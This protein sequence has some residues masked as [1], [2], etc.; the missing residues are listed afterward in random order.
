MI[1][2][3]IY[4]LIFV[5]AF[6]VVR[7]LASRLSARHDF[8]SLKTVTFG[9]ESAVRPDRWASVISLLTIFL[10]WGAFTGSKLVPVH[11]PGPFVG[12]TEFTYTLQAPDG[13]TD[14]A[15]IFVRVFPIGEDV[16]QR[17]TE[18]GPGFAKNDSITVGAWRSQL[19]LFDKN[20]EITR[21][22][23]AQVIDVNVDDGMIDGVK[24]MTRLHSFSAD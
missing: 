19:I 3:V 20:D 11:V 8:T 5:A 24:A 15:T 21:K 6:I 14:D 7:I 10:L 16:E 13:S 17:A 12:D 1:P 18:P 22:D 2:L 9:D 23:G 4:V